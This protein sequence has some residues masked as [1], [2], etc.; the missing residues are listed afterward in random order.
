[1]IVV[2]GKSGVS[3]GSTTSLVLE[4]TKPRGGVRWLT[5]VKRQGQPTELSGLL[6]GKLL[7]VIEAMHMVSGCYSCC[8]TGTNLEAPWSMS[9]YMITIPDIEIG[10]Y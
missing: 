1:M 7:C 3:L 5:G 4:F 6:H 10:R 8:G 9:V 2:R